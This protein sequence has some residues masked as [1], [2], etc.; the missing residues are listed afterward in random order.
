MR[1]GYCIILIVMGWVLGLSMN[2]SNYMLQHKTEVGVAYTDGS[3]EGYREGYTDCEVDYRGYG[4]GGT[5]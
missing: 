5:R 3:S 2:L 4:D 1:L